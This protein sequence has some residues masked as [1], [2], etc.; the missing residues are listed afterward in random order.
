MTIKERNKKARG[1]NLWISRKK[2]L[3]QGDWG[4]VL[5]ILNLVNFYL[6]DGYCQTS[7]L[8]WHIKKK[9]TILIA[10]RENWR[11]FSARNR[12]QVHWGSMSW[13]TR[14]RLWSQSSVQGRPACDCPTWERE[15]ASSDFNYLCLVKNVQNNNWTTLYF[16]DD[17]WYLN[18]TCPHLR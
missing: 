7:P 16:I 10:F 12:Q 13:M 4:S 18:N 3:N 8:H 15:S 1:R 2:N 11:Y 6:Y 5:R 14:H 17:I 9:E